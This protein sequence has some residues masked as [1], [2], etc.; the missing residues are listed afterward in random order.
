[1]IGVVAL[2]VLVVA[3][4]AVLSRFSIVGSTGVNPPEPGSDDRAGGPAS[5]PE[6]D[7]V[8]GW[9]LPGEPSRFGELPPPPP[10]GPA[11]GTSQVPT[12]WPAPPA[13]RHERGDRQ[14]RPAFGAIVAATV[15]VRFGRDIVERM[16]WSRYGG[17]GLLAVAAGAVG[18]MVG[19]RLVMR[20]RVRAQGG[21]EFTREFVS[22]QI[23]ASGLGGPAFDEDGTLV[24]ASILVVNQRPKI[25]E[26]KTDYE[27][28][29]SN[30]API[31]AIRQIG[32]SRAKLAVRL[33]TRFDQFFTHHFELRDLEGRP[34][35]RV[36]RPRKIFLTKLHVFTGDDRYLGTI[37]QQNVFWKIRFG[38]A[39]AGGATIAHLRA[40]NLRAWDFTIYDTLERPVATVLKSWE[41][42]ARTAFT[43]ADHYVV[44]IHVRLPEPL[45]QLVLAAA[46]ATD[47]ALKQDARGIM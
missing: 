37:K 10:T 38:I 9:P 11:S 23:A 27:V 14:G 31:G 46:L 1:V 42:W 25:L 35:L 19:W 29:G 34:V 39:A 33:I 13:D 28:F 15:A 47:L 21:V 7:P 40:E 12:P 43:R 6:V 44:R 5:W 2:V 8:T 4:C 17:L 20:A 18:L 24:N 32:Q 3:A 45:N 22:R 36:T 30:G 16:A 26:A 41:G